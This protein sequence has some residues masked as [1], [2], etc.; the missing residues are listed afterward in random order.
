VNYLLYLIFPAIFFLVVIF[1]VRQ[2]WLPNPLKTNG[3]RYSYHQG[4]FRVTGPLAEYMI[5]ISF[6]GANKLPEQFQSQVQPLKGNLYTSTCIDF[7]NSIITI[8]NRNPSNIVISNINPHFGVR[9]YTLGD[10]INGYPIIF[11]TCLNK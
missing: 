11:G 8:D 7:Y 3:N 4:T 9:I 2:N 6:Q 5:T 10:P 1:M